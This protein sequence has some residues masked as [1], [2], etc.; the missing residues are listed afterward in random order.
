M[1]FD[2]TVLHILEEAN[3]RHVHISGP[4]RLHAT[5]HHVNCKQLTLKLMCC[6][7]HVVSLNI[8]CTLYKYV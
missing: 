1:N 4:E 2:K 8:P 5:V 6:D 3:K 7:I